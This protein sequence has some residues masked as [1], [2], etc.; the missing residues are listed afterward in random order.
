MV[1]A[2]RRV[3]NPV[4]LRFACGNATLVV[5]GKQFRFAGNPIVT[6]EIMLTLVEARVKSD[7]RPALLGTALICT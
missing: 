5:T 7:E 4:P 1:W 3:R 6:H 2:R